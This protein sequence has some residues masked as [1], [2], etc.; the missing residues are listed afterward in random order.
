MWYTNFTTDFTQ[1]SFTDFIGELQALETDITDLWG[2][3]ASGDIDL[4]LADLV[5]FLDGD[6]EAE[7]PVD[8]IITPLLPYLTDSAT[9]I[10]CA[11]SADASNWTI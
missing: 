8:P 5:A 6:P 7:P 2:S 11:V 3:L 4:F 9:R 1:A 10:G